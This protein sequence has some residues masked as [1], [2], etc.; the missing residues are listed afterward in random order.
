MDRRE[1]LR[2]SAAAAAGVAGAG[3]LGAARARAAASARALRQA[4]GRP[5]RQAQG[6]ANVVVILV[7]DMGFSDLGCY[8]GEVRTPNLDGLARRGLRFSQFYNTAKCS[9]TRATL[10]SGLYFPEVGEM[11]LRDCMT[12]GEAMKRA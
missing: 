8:G 2:R 9:P 6:R 11:Q 3:L 12:L 4:Q 5:P 10:L 1:F 7:D